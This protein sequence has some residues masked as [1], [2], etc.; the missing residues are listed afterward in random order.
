MRQNARADGAPEDRAVAFFWL[1]PY[2]G[3]Y[4]SLELAQRD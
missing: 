4:I 3:T 2:N 1:N